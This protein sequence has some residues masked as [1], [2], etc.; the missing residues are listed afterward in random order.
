MSTALIGASSPGSGRFIDILW[1]N[2]FATTQGIERLGNGAGAAV[3]ASNGTVGA[4]VLYKGRWSLP[5]PFSAVTA[6]GLSWSSAFKLSPPVEKGSGNL[7]GLDDVGCFRVMVIQAFTGPVTAV[8]S[9]MDVGFQLLP[10]AGMQGMVKDTWNGM[11]FFYTGPNAINYRV[12]K[13]KASAPYDYDAVIPNIITADWNAYE[14]RYVGPSSVADGVMKAYVNGI[15]VASHA[16]GAGTILPQP[17][18]TAPTYGF[19]PVVWN[20]ING[21]TT[22]P[23][24]QVRVIAGPTEASLL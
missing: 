6:T 21:A 13:T 5:L 19:L 23:V 17:V 4:G 10:G 11:G 16:Y 15:L 8:G 24:A 18:T 14:I 22:A 1:P 3:M 12:R 7:L 20:G 2:N 9:L